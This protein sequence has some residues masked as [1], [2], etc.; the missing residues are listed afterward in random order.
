MTIRK[1]IFPIISVLLCLVSTS[2]NNEEGKTQPN[3]S[4]DTEASKKT[5]T[6]VQT[7][8]KA[9]GRIRIKEVGAFGKVFNDS[10]KSQYAYAEKLGID[11]ITDLKSI[12]EA[13]RP[14][15]KIVSNEYY[16]VDTLTHSL[17]YL[18][19]EAASLL[20]TIGKN[21]IDTLSNRGGYGY[22]IKVTSVLRTPTTVKKLRK[23]NINATDSSTHQFGT[24]FDIS[25]TNFYRYNQN[26]EIDIYTLKSLLAEVLLDLRNQNKCLVKYERKTGCFHITT[27]K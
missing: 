27:T 19:P 14:L 4:L 20:T 11:P 18:V 22:R 1:L 3:Q 9:I 25:H 15:V 2:C 16:H 12:Y 13:K 10:N 7:E 6:S 8:D 24:T 26:A 23:V 21:F 17:P 5:Q